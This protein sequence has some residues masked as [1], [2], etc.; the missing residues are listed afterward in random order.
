M[1]SSAIRRAAPASPVSAA[2][3]TAQVFPLAS[4]IN[5]PCTVAAPGKMILEG[6]R[7]TVR[8]EGNAVV[9]TA[10][11]TIKAA[12]LGALV[13]PATPLTAANWT[14][15]GSGTARAVAAPGSVPWW[16]E[17]LCIYDSVGGALQGIFNQMANNLYDSLAPLT[18]TLAGINGTN[19]TVSQAGSPVLPSDPVAYFAVAF[20]F[21]TAGANSANIS[22]FELAF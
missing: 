13:I 6:K 8:A 1:S 10:A 16:I 17:A 20:T 5:L 15:L 4:N 2:V 18:G 12:L 9:S 3:A 11:Y 14:T 19:Q 7:F 21:G 22:N